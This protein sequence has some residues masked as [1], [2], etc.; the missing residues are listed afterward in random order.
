MTIRDLPII[1]L[2]SIMKF[3]PENIY[4]IYNRG[5][6]G[7]KIFFKDENY[8]FFLK[9]LRKELLPFCELLCYCLMP[10]HFH[11]MVSVNNDLDT[12][13][14]NALNNAIGT[15]LRS[16]TR[17]INIQQNRNGSLFQQKTKA[18]EL[19]DKSNNTTIN[20]ISIC[21]HY[22]HQNPLRAKLV[23]DLESWKFSSYLDYAGLRNGSLCNQELFFE[24]TGIR[25]EEFVKESKAM[26]PKNI[27]EI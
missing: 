24:L 5:N 20:Y 3:N 26:I 16:Y 18:K 6:N 12:N 2:N 13:N 19:I 8:L 23:G 4:H 17:A 14:I 11:L 25:K 21:G 10:N 9:K 22:I 1:F 27:L 7:Q 15:L